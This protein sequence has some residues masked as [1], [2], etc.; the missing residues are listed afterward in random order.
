MIYAIVLVYLFYLVYKYDICGLRNGKEKNYTILC[1]IFVCVAGISYHVG[2]DTIGY[3]Y[4]FK[5]YKG[6]L[7][8]QMYD[9][10]MFANSQEPLWVLINVFFSRTFGDFQFLKFAIALFF[11]STI[12]WFVKKYSKKPFFSILIY[13][14][15]LFLHLN[16]Q[17]LRESVAISFFL[18]A[19]DK[20]C[21]EKKNYKLYYLFCFIACFVHR[22]SFFTLV[23]PL[24]AL[25]KPNKVYYAL[26]AALLLAAPFIN[27]LVFSSG[28][29]LLNDTI[30]GSLQ[31]FMES[32]EYGIAS[33]SIFGII[34]TIIKIIPLGLFLNFS[35]N[36]KFKSIA[37]VYLLMYVFNSVS[38]GILFRINDYLLLPF[39]VAAAD[40]LSNLQSNYRNQTIKVLFN[41]ITIVFFLSTLSGHVTAKNWLEYYPYSSVFTKTILM[42]RENLLYYMR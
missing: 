14:S 29:F 30:S 35:G 21:G 4:T 32:D 5:R 39:T 9:G 6:M 3:E 19:Y 41:I 34:H 18:I 31:H 25:I 7:F 1:I 36:S 23:V 38:I 12:F 8:S 10:D 16:F 24:C 26:L 2:G 20:I 13:A 42:E 22:F 28:L 27:N 37:A 11:N 17:V 33:K 15:L 40:S